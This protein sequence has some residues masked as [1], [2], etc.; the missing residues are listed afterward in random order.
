MYVLSQVVLAGRACA[1][2]YMMYLSMYS[3]PSTDG[4]LPWL[5]RPCGMCL[6]FTP[7]E[8]PALMEHGCGGVGIDGIHAFPIV[9]ATALFSSSPLPS[10]HS[11]TH[12]NPLTPLLIY[13]TPPSPAPQS[14]SRFLDIDIFLLRQSFV[15]I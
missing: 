11:A 6:F 9:I 3:T 5:A 8:R 1:F 7:P 2:T 12:I 13:S 10:K 15:R 4:P 14:W